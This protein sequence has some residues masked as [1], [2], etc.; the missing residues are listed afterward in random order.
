MAPIC[1]DSHHAG[2]KHS[3]YNNEKQKGNQYTLLII[4]RDRRKQCSLKGFRKQS[5]K[6]I[7]RKERD[8]VRKR[9]EEKDKLIIIFWN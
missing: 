8:E 6:I 5:K 3:K 1:S 2:R 4:V 7:R 9:S